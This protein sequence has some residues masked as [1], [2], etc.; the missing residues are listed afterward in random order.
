MR[1]H[2]DKRDEDRRRKH[3]S[4]LQDGQDWRRNRILPKA[5]AKWPTCL[6]VCPA[7]VVGNW[8]RELET[9]GYFE[10]GLYTESKKERKEVLK[11]FAWGRLDIRK[12]LDGHAF[13]PPDISFAA[14]KSHHLAGSR[15]HGH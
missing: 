6:I 5:N 14:L 7:P 10:V 15:T 9:W 2:G 12:S 4:S 1:K 11:D 8:Q 13:T 3:V